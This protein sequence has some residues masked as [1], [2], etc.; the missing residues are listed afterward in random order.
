VS[1]TSKEVEQ[2][3]AQS[4]LIL[5]TKTLKLF[6]VIRKIR[7]LARLFYSFPV[8]DLMKGRKD[9]RVASLQEIQNHA[10]PGV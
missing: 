8:R 6:E 5:M 3:L 2:K 4:L 7:L 10:Y 1:V 9:G